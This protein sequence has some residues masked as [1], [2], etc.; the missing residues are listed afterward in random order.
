MTFS[1]VPTVEGL[2]RGAGN[3][4][5]TAEG[6]QFAYVLAKELE[7]NEELATDELTKV[8][9]KITTSKEKN[10]DMVLTQ[11]VFKYENDKIGERLSIKYI[12]QLKKY[13]KE[14]PVEER[15]IFLAILLSLAK[16]ESIYI[17]SFLADTNTDYV[18]NSMAM[19]KERFALLDEYKRKLVVKKEMK[20]LE[21]EEE[22]LKEYREALQKSLFLRRKSVTLNRRDKNFYWDVSLSNFNA[23][24]EVNTL[25]MKELQ[26]MNENRKVFIGF[27][28]YILFNGL[29]TLPRGMN[30]IVDEKSKYEVLMNQL[31]HFKNYT[32]KDLLKRYEKI[33]ENPLVEANHNLTLM[34]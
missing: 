19:D 24:F 14:I 33:K 29:H 9:V 21:V 32:R 17:S 4:D 28:D 2:F 11:E 30:I 26:F 20:E 16:N 8:Y 6:V 7:D 25:Q 27:N 15:R 10:R 1:A 12:P 34:F 3:S 13:I 23:K 31:R 18:E 22:K 5:I